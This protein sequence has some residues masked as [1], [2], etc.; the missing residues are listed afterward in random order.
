MC[1]WPLIKSGRCS[2]AIVGVLLSEI[3][4][5]RVTLSVTV[6]V[7]LSVTVRVTLSVTVRVTLSVTVRVTLS[8]T[9]T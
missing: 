8:L 1:N 9:V 6:R 3:F 4:Q 2:I 5:F 7:T